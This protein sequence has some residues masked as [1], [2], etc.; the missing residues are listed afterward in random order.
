MS[1]VPLMPKQTAA[2]Y[3]IEVSQ[4]VAPDAAIGALLTDF[5]TAGLPGVPTPF[6]EMGGAAA[7][8]REPHRLVA[9]LREP[10]VA[11]SASFDIE[12]FDY[13][14]R[15][16]FG[17]PTVTAGSGPDT[18]FSQRLFQAGN[19]VS[20]LTL[21]AGLGGETRTATGLV[22]D[23]LEIPLGRTDGFRTI[24]ASYLAFELA[25]QFAWSPSTTT[26]P[27]TRYEVP[28]FVARLLINTVPFAFVDGTLT[29][30][31]G[32]TRAPDVNNRD[33]LTPRPGMIGASIAATIEVTSDT[34]MDTF[35]RALT[36]SDDAVQVE[37]WPLASN[38]R[39]VLVDLPFVRISAPDFDVNAGAT[40]VT[41]SV[42]ITAGP[43]PAGSARSVAVQ[44][45]RVS[46]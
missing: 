16:F 20:P 25:R 17:A 43:D 24:T 32:A 2:I 30:T 5:R 4:G 34:Q 14:L 44:V 31:G 3:G 28:G 9:G 46:P 41:A 7:S 6:A 36:G 26:A 12:N 39:R 35:T 19:S 23:S 8:A 38:R 22:G 15:P 40:N 21:R 42:N 37:F 45:W 33:V 10:T 29:I 1:T 27:R 11:V 13:L 18:G